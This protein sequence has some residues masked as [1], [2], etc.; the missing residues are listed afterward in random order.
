[1]K[2]LWGTSCATLALSARVNVDEMLGS[3]GTSAVLLTL[4]HPSAWKV[5]S[6]MSVY[7]MLH[8]S[9]LGN[10]HRPG[11]EVVRRELTTIYG[12]LD[13]YAACCI[14]AVLCFDTSPKTQNYL[15]CFSARGWGVVLQRY[16]SS[17]L[18]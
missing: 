15:S 11:K 14:G 10:G 5:D 6:P 7:R 1:V 18:L 3:S 2:S 4:I 13:E 9:T 17:E 12:T 16:A 8:N